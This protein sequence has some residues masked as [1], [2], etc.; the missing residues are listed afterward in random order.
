MIKVILA[1]SYLFDNQFD[2]AK[3]IYLENKNT[4]LRDDARTFRQAVLDDF[5]ELQEAGITH[6]DVKKIKA[7]LTSE[8]ESR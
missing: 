2:K 6:P 7:L 8:T 3:A 4:K 5:K 1:H